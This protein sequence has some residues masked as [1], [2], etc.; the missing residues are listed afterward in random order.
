MSGAVKT[1]RN[2]YNDF[3]GKTAKKAAK[4]AGKLQYAAAQE[5]SQN[6]GDMYNQL[7]PS[8]SP[9]TQ[10]GTTALGKMNNLI[11]S[12]GFGQIGQF[13]FNQDDPSYQWRFNQGADAIAAQA[14]AMGQLGSGNL[15]TALVDYG[16][17]AASQEYQNAYNRWVQSQQLQQNAQNSA[18]N[19]LFGLGQMGMGATEDL[20]NLGMGAALNQANLLIG[21]TGALAQ[22]K[23]DA[24]NARAAGLNNII[25]TVSGGLGAMAGNPSAIAN[26]GSNMGAMLP[27]L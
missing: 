14:S 24:A 27:F 2:A 1:V 6:I 10:I 18:Y 13:Q 22:S 21:G 26:I 20:S 11:S 5:A 15:G 12:P 25:G 4:K 16:Q 7:Q 8:Y 19:T 3:T 23:V 17:N 9:Y